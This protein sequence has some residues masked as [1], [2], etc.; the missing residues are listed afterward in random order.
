MLIGHSADVGSRSVSGYSPVRIVG[1]DS[2]VDGATE[3]AL[4]YHVAWFARRAKFGKRWSLNLPSR[5]ISEASGS[6]SKTTT[7][8]GPP[9]P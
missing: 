7:A 3:V 8:T 6:S 5:V 4:R 9:V 1:T 2:G